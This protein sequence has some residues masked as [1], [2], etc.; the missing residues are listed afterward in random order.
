[1]TAGVWKQCEETQKPRRPVRTVRWTWVREIR[2]ESIPCHRR[3]GGACGAAHGRACTKTQM[4]EN[5]NGPYDCGRFI[6][7][8]YVL[9]SMGHSRSRRRHE[10]YPSALKS[11]IYNLL[12][13][14]VKKLSGSKID[15]RNPKMGSTKSSKH[16]FSS[17]SRLSGE[18][19]R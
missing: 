14:T 12:R 16:R 18:K 13:K 15:P 17:R 4:H 6:Y 8:D 2:S 7:W 10:K 3:G 19:R 5:A 11:L 1:V 9:W